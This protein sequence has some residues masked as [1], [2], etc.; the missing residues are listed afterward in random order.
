MTDTFS[1]GLTYKGIT[2]VKV[3]NGTEVV[4][5]LSEG[6]SGYTLDITDTEDGPFTLKLTV[7]GHDKLKEWRNA[8]YSIVVDYTAELN[9]GAVAGNSG[10]P[11]SINL[12][13]SVHSEDTSPYTTP[14]DTVITYTNN[15]ALTKTNGKEGAER[16]LLAGATFEL[17]RLKAGAVDLADSNS[18]VLVDTQTTGNGQDGTT[19]GVANFIKMEQGT[20]KLK[21][22]VA[23]TGYNLLTEPIIF[24]VT[25]NGLPETVNNGSETITWSTDNDSI[26]VG[27][28]T[29]LL[30]TEIVNTAGFILPGTGGA[31]TALF[32]MGGIV[33]IALAGT[34]FFI[35]RKKSGTC[36][37]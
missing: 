23:P 19:E 29:G 11:N 1:D 26:T 25:A 5:T 8:G 31:G 10:N 35:Y 2:S 21:E 7:P 33:L 12:T 14:D 30:G 15:L 34:V 3:M 17:Y 20:Y 13:Y 27:E 18:W 9:S 24:T 32:T 22:T 4:E 36:A 6:N 37:K 28:T 16:Q